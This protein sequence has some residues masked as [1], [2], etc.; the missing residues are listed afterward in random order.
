MGQRMRNT[1]SWI[2]F[3]TMLFAL[4][5]L[6]GLFAS[7]ATSI[8][9][10]RGMARSTTLDRA[11]VEG[12]AADGAARLERLRPALGV[13]A[14]QVIDGLGPLQDRVAAAR[15]TVLDEQRRE[16]AS[17][18]FR[19][20]LMLAVVT[21]LAAGLGGGIVAMAGRTPNRTGSSTH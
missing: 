20:R 5:G 19:I 4:V 16:E 8:P 2:A 12:S 15:M 17:V 11:L 14:N 13:L 10:E 18:A 9:L 3:L 7:F 1:G 6:C 21:V